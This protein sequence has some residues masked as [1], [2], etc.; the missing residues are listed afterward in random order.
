MPRENLWEPNSIRTHSG[1]YINIFDPKPY[2][3]SIEDIAWGLSKEQRF[4]N[5]LPVQYNVADHSIG[6]SLL[7][8]DNPFDGL[9]HD[10][11]DAYIGDLASPIKNLMPDFKKVEHELM[12]FMANHFGFNWTSPEETKQ[13]DRYMLELEWEA[14]MLNKSD[15]DEQKYFRANILSQEQAYDRFL[16]M[17]HKYKP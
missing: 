7:C 4:G 11:S 10:I 14:I 16:Q 15:T 1:K 13:A 3:I 8:I 12:A 5:H 9:M 17:F 2:M 6:V